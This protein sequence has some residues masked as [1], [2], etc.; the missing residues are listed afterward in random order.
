MVFISLIYGVSVDCPA[1]IS[2]AQGLRVQSVRPALWTALQGDCCNTLVASVNRDTSICVNERV[3]EISWWGLGLNGILNATAMPPM[4]IHLD[5][6]Q[7]FI[8]GGIPAGLPSGLRDLVLYRNQMTGVIPGLPVGLVYL[9]LPENRFSGSLPS[10]LPNGLTR[11]YLEDNNF[12]GELPIFPSTLYTISLGLS[13]D[14]RTNHFSGTLSLNKPRRIFINNN[15]ITDIII[16]D[17]TALTNCD[18]SNN[19]L[20]GNSR[21]AN[22]TICVKT[23]LY[24]PSLL[25]NS[26]TTTKSPLIV[27]IFSTP[28]SSATEHFTSS[29]AAPSSSLSSAIVLSPSSSTTVPSPPSTISAE[30][31]AFTTL[32]R[33]HTDTMLTQIETVLE[34]STLIETVKF[35]SLTNVLNR[36]EIIQIICRIFLNL[37]LLAKVLRATPWRRELK[38][39]MTMKNEVISNWTH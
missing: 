3:T 33:K 34:F 23:G 4:L 7:N 30:T 25:P 26:Q 13:G 24:S 39:W 11:I 21:V 32:N 6:N 5:L 1:L 28:F 18:L 31:I 12:T 16:Q 29:S 14:V 2:F 36:F 20:L 17:S 37:M 8:T 35:Q 22:L 10:S 9:D 38:N 27:T 19:P 15:L